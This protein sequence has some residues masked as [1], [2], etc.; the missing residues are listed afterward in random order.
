MEKAVAEAG[1]C[2]VVVCLA[3]STLLWEL[4]DWYAALHPRATTWRRRGA[5]LACV[6]VAETLRRGDR[7]YIGI[8]CFS[9]SGMATRSF[10]A[11]SCVWLCSWLVRGS[12]TGVVGSYHDTRR[13]ELASRECRGEPGLCSRLCAS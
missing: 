5:L 9:L 4:C 3:V 2:N 13:P 12:C 10:C 11:A 7:F 1:V 6:Q 8:F